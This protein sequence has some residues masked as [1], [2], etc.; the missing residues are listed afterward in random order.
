MTA[1]EER[2]VSISV[3]AKKKAPTSGKAASS[4][5]G[6]LEHVLLAGSD[7]KQTKE[8]RQDEVT[9]RFTDFGLGR[10]VD[11]TRAKP[12]LNKTSFQV[13]PLRFGKLIGTE[14]GGSVEAYE[15]V[16][17]SVQ[18]LQLE[19]KQSVSVSSAPVNIGTDGE[20]TRSTSNMRHVVGRRVHN[21]TI[22]FR[23]EFDEIPFAGSR[24][25]PT[26]RVL[27]AAEGEEAQPQKMAPQV[28][29]EPTF[30]EKL[31]KWVLER[32]C[33]E[34]KCDSAM[35]ERVRAIGDESPVVIFE[36]WFEGVP[37]AEHADT[38]KQI[39]EL[40][41]DF[42]RC[43]HVTHYVSSLNLGA[44]EYSVITEEDYSREM[45]LA[46]SF[47][48]EDVVSV[49]LKPKGKYSLRKTRKSTRVKRVGLIKNPDSGDYYVPRGTYAEAVI[50]VEVKPIQLLVRHQ[51]L[52]RSLRHAVA[53]YIEE[54]RDTSST[55]HPSHYV[56]SLCL[57]LSIML[58]CSQEE[59]LSVTR[60]I[61]PLKLF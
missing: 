35:R 48:L 47:G 31:A 60:T 33:R 44:L 15:D 25:Q 10:G 24:A 55:C 45:G 2:P 3:E 22:S 5:F 19:L 23:E 57:I 28:E 34:G 58:G 52:R 51:Y 49:V 53:H 37:P 1:L 6:R 14:Q 17:N 12:W 20:H 21:R 8:A 56:S 29:E 11:A 61:V 38:L 54:Q 41:L 43:F 40:C 32:L 39:Y 59:V 42:V 50:G 16:V 18:T 27:L 36:K 7:P 30:E 13:R 9:Q 26:T 46:G 4:Q